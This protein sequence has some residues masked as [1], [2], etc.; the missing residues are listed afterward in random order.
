MI[1]ILKFST[2]VKLFE[3]KINCYGRIKRTISMKLIFYNLIKPNSFYETQE[4]QFLN[5]REED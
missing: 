4:S 1:E 2:T 3:M 5:L